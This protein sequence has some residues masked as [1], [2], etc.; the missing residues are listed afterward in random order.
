[1]CFFLTQSFSKNKMFEWQY[2]R[3]LLLTITSA[4][5]L[6]PSEFRSYVELLDD[7]YETKLSS[8]TGA[9]TISYFSTNARE[10]SL[11]MTETNKFGLPNCVDGQNKCR[12]IGIVG[13]GKYFSAQQSY[14]TEQNEFFSTKL[15][16]YIHCFTE[17]QDQIFFSLDHRAYRI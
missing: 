12:Q 8:P 10:L 4:L 3:F 17:A 6:T 7:P 13:A 2:L 14:T 5:T 16:E 11:Q 9:N 15:C 1:M